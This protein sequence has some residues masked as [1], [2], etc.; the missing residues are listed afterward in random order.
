MSQHAQWVQR[1]R[2]AGF[3]EDQ[4]V[5]H[6]IDALEA[7]SE[8]IND[9]ETVLAEHYGVEKELVHLRLKMGADWFND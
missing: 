6:L 9:Y 4:I 7:H 8:V 3:S 5:T 1:M 2:R